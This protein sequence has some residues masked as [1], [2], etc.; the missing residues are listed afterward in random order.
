[1]PGRDVKSAR[2]AGREYRPRTVPRFAL[3]LAGAAG[4]LAWRLGRTPLVDSA[5]VAELLS[6]GFVCAVDRA[7]ERIGF[8]AEIGLEEGLKATWRWYQENGW[9]AVESVGE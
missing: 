3:R 4:D 6:P 7:R 1:M 9:I 8:A 5:R 2:L